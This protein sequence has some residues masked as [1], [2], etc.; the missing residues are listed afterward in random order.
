M[1]ELP[2]AEDINYWKTGRSSPD[3]WIAKTER[4]I[5]S[6][7]GKVLAEAFGKDASGNSAFMLAF[8]IGEDKFK[9]IFPVLP[10]KSGNEGAARIQAATMLYHDIKSKCISATVLG[11]RAAFFSYLL[12]TDGKTTTDF[13][14]DDLRPMLNDLFGTSTNLL[15]SGDEI[16]EGEYL[17]ETK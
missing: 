13:E 6:L 4:Q 7:D 17:D 5:Q 9:V 8:E 2:Y 15:A 3:T 16:I 14:T 11:T 1:R 10:S 12:L